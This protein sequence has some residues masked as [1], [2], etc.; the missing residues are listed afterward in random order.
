LLLIVKI[1]LKHTEFSWQDSEILTSDLGGT[2]KINQGLK[3]SPFNILRLLIM[4]INNELA[5]H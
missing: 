2:Y 1:A 4:G 5:I 3:V